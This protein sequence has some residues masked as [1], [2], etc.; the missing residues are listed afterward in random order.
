MPFEVFKKGSAP[1]AGVPSVT[2]QKR[3]LFSLND[4]A[5][6][7]IDEPAAVQFLWDE[8]E[9]LIAVRPAPPEDPDAYPAREQTA[10]KARP[11][12]KRG[13]TLVAGSMFSRFIGLDTSVAKRWVPKV[14]DGMLIIDLKEDGQVVVAN[15][16]RGT[17]SADRSG[18]DDD[19][20]DK[21]DSG[22]DG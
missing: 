2:I 12:G 18:D 5:M 4:A 14:V 20:D 6:K 19:D 13:A 7:L 21:S 22:D 10:N 9:R 17:Q 16:N 8:T 11:G 1:I 3:G 15:R